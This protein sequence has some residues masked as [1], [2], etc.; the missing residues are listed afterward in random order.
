MFTRWGVWA[1]QIN[2]DCLLITSSRTLSGTWTPIT[3]A[4]SAAVTEIDGDFVHASLRI[5]LRGQVAFGQTLALHGETQAPHPFHGD[6]RIVAAGFYC[7]CS[8]DPLMQNISLSG[9]LDVFLLKYRTT[10][11]TKE[12]SASSLFYMVNLNVQFVRIWRNGIL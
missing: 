9:W 7:C 10:T 4:D 11:L 12:K 8:A 1:P 2:C 5:R 3:S 6:Q